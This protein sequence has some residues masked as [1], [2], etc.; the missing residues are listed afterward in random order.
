ME[1][2][3]HALFADVLRSSLYEMMAGVVHRVA[4]VLPARANGSRV[5]G[6]G[7]EALPDR[8]ELAQTVARDVTAT[9]SN[10]WQCAGLIQDR[11]PQP[12]DVNEIVRQAIEMTRNIWERTPRDRKDSV[13]LV[14]D[15]LSEP[16]MATTSIALLGV[17]VHA[18]QGVL[19]APLRGGRIHI[20]TM[21]DNDHVLIVVRATASGT[22]DA[23]RKRVSAYPLSTAQGLYL[24]LGFTILRAFAIRHGGEATLLSDDAGGVVLTLRLPQLP[25]EAR[26]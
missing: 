22:G 25:T 7:A 21:Q 17:M 10:L 20:R 9:L 13:E 3:A 8:K 4:T 2:T 14:F 24:Q 5:T 26:R 15:P 18:L 6:S 1:R 12:R 19:A 11:P 23:S 16:V